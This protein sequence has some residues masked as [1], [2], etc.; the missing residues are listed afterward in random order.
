MADY[1]PLLARAIETQANKGRETREMIYARARKALLAQLNGA[2][3][4]LAPADIARQQDF[5]EVAIRRVEADFGH[6]DVAE[7][8]SPAPPPIAPA[9]PAADAPAAPKPVSGASFSDKPDMSPPFSAG[10]KPPVATPA[11]EAGSPPEERHLESSP[12]P[13]SLSD[14]ADDLWSHTERPAI[15][16]DELA[17]PDAEPHEGLLPR[18]AVKGLVLKT[19]IG[20]AVLAVGLGLY[21]ERDRLHGLFAGKTGSAPVTAT[22]PA[23]SPET[24]TKSTDRI[25]QAPTTTQPVPRAATN[26]PEV[27]ST[28]RAILLE[29]TAGG[30]QQLQQFLGNV[31]WSTETFIPAGGQTKDVGIRADIDIPDRNFKATITIRRNPDPNIPASHIVDIQFHLPADFDYGNVQSVPGMQAVVSE[32]AQGTPLRGLAVRVAPGYFLIGLVADERERQ[33]NLRL[34][35]S[36]AL[37]SIPIV[38]DNGRRAILILDKGA[39]GDQAFRDAFTAWG[40][41]PAQGAPQP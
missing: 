29:E 4:P 7:P 20:L 22:A 37:L 15:L 10:S 33:Y 18:S 21:L 13:R 19:V 25:A 26:A 5:L 23:P 12:R 40:L 2:T 11:P 28:P 34:L 17:A 1:Y 35:I 27:Q 31:T 30:G 14:E 32:G 41:M 8:A 36:R 24:T 16:D 9:A 39:S 38:F 3:P 6:G